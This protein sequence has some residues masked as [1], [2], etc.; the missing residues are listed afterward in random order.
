MPRC[1]IDNAQHNVNFFKKFDLTDYETLSYYKIRKE[2]WSRHIQFCLDAFLFSN[3]AL[4][5]LAAPHSLPCTGFSFLLHLSLLPTTLP[6]S[7][8]DYTL[9]DVSVDH[10]YNWALREVE[11]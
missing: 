5:L 4:P 11:V 8:V 1:V 2:Q 9:L 10:L 7:R 6:S 3:P